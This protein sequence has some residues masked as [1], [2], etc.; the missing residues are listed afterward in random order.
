M[1]AKIVYKDYNQNES[2]LFPPTLGELVPKNHPV[3]IVNAVI[4]RLDISSVESTYKGGGTSS[5][6]PRMLLKVIV[7]SYLCNVYSGRRLERLLQENV[8]YMWLSGMSRP[9]FR[10][11]NRFRSGRLADGR[12]DGL[13]RQVVLLLNAEGLVSL[14]VQYID[15]TKIESVA[16]RYTFVWKRSVEKNKEKLEAKVDAVLKTAES[17][18]SEENRECA[19]EESGDGSGRAYGKGTAQ[20]GRAGYQRQKAEEVRREG[21]GRVP[22]EARILQASSGDLGGKEQLQQDGQGRDVH[23]YEGGRDAQRSDQAGIQCPD[24]DREPVH[25]QL[26]HLL[27]AHGLGYADTVPEVVQGKIR[28][29]ERRDSRGLGLWQRAELRVHGWRGD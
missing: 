5:F 28:P 27:E 3:R 16:N 26:R 25:N 20:D 8:N 13:F 17:V 4:D 9:D 24:S 21:E 18:L 6:H 2:L 10:T 11:I 23:A 15:G 1:S 22:S 7:Y 12:F 19:S 14:K 29:A